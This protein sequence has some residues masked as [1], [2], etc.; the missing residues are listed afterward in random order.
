[1]T[2]IGL[3]LEECLA[4]DPVGC[5]PVSG[6]NSLLSGKITGNF[7]KNASYQPE[8]CVNFAQK[9]GALWRDSLWRGTGNGFGL[10]REG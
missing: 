9:F 3:E 4:D 5:E 2:A 1:M 7:R 10:N 6:R 8:V